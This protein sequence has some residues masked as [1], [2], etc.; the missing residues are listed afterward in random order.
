MDDFQAA[1]SFGDGQPEMF[2]VGEGRQP[3]NWVGTLWLAL[4]VALTMRLVPT[5]HLLFFA[6][7]KK[8]KQKKGDPN[9]Q[10]RYANFPHSA[11][12]FRR[13]RTSHAARVVGQVHAFSRKK[14]AAFGWT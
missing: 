12:F 7:P 9:V 5:G 13:V 2:F 10:V 6:S 3:E 4:R 1:L 11:S 8:S 14:N